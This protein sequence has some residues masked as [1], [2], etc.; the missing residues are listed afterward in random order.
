M[1][2]R[3]LGRTGVRVSSLC[4]GTMTWGQQNSEAD[5]HAQMDYAL[6]QGINFFDTFGN[7]FRAAQGGDAGFNRAHHRNLVPRA[8]QSRQGHPGDQV[9]PDARR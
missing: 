1:E 4:L 2:Y 3:E 9:S 5:G 8:G 6:A 7:V